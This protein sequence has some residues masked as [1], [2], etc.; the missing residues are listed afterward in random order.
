MSDDLQQARVEAAAKAMHARDLAKSKELYPERP[1]MWAKERPAYAEYA[2]LALAAA[3]A[4]QSKAKLSQNF[5][6]PSMEQIEKV[7]AGNGLSG[8][9]ELHGW[10]CNH[11]EVY[12]ECR[13]VSELIDDLAALF[14]EA[15]GD[16]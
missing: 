14:G 12:G 5:A 13:C 1:S 9:G 3:D 16:E 7:L 10:R 8:L 11:P 6:L 4:I 2:A 15:A